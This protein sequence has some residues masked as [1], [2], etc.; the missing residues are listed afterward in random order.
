MLSAHEYWFSGFT[1][2]FGVHALLE[3]VPVH[4]TPPT[5]FPISALT[6]HSLHSCWKHHHFSFPVLDNCASPVDHTQSFTSAVHSGPKLS[7]LKNSLGLLPQQAPVPRAGLW[8]TGLLFESKQEPPLAAEHG[9]ALES[10]K[11]T[12]KPLPASWWFV[13]V[14][15]GAVV[16]GAQFR[17]TALEESG[18]WQF[19]PAE[20]QNWPAGHSVARH[21]ALLVQVPALQ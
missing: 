2:E 5:F 19:P 12:L 9:P 16:S 6:L 7:G 11:F 3:A 18:A 17:Q 8:L 14:H 4:V 20:S 1:K 21:W 15:V 10:N 13:A